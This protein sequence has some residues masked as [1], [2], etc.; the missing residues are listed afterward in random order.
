M[1]SPFAEPRIAFI[2]GFLLWEVLSLM[3]S[4]DVMLNFYLTHF[5]KLAPLG[6]VWGLV[7]V[8]VFWSADR[9]MKWRSDRYVREIAERMRKS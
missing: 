7:T 1:E 9:F 4:F 6:I 2:Y 3:N 5:L 8:G